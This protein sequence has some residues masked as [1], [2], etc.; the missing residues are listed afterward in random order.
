MRCIPIHAQFPRTRGSFTKL[1]LAAFD[2]SLTGTGVAISNGSVSTVSTLK[3]PKTAKDGMP[4]LHWILDQL[5]QTVIIV[6]PKLVVMEDLAFAAHDREH[7]RAGLA[8]LV[9]YFL[10]SAKIP[11]ILV[12]PTSLKKFVTGSGK[13]EKSMMLMDVYKRWGIEA[14]NDNEADAYALLRIGIVLTGQAKIETRA[15]KETL[16]TISKNN[17]EAIKQCSTK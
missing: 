5:K 12:A 10:W 14:K 13:A 4:R 8:Y 11:Y 2:L 17:L 7:Q 6:T 15:Q 16:A 1:N 3:P 9:R